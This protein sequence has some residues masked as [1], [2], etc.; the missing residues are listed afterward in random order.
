[1]SK[2]DKT[3][4]A[5]QGASAGIATAIAFLNVAMIVVKLVQTVTEDTTILET[6]GD[7][8]QIEENEA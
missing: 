1:M 5:L 2:F 8:E 7:A 6:E 3:R 4:K